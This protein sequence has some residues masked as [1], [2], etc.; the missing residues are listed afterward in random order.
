MSQKI[1]PQKKRKF[2][3]LTKK[4]GANRNFVATRRAKGRNCEWI[5]VNK[6][7]KKMRKSRS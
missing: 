5:N 7:D 3:H 4:T 6:V 1:I 2:K